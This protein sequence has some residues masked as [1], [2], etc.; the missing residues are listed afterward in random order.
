V[1]PEWVSKLADDKLFQ[2]VAG[3][4]AIL[5]LLITF[6][7]WWI[8]SRISERISAN[9]RLPALGKQLANDLTELNRLN[10]ANAPSHEIATCLAMCRSRL[11]SIRH[12][13][14]DIRARRV[15]RAKISIARLAAMFAVDRVVRSLSYSVYGELQE[16]V[17]DIE[18]F[19][20]RIPL[21][22]TDA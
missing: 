14:S 13:K 6:R 10:L 16:V 1:W 21:R 18:E 20:A 19:T 22:G 2:S 17:E 12:Y 7:V 15:V 5:A 8:T 11:R 4:A 9:V 3:L